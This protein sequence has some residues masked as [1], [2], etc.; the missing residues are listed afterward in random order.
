MK[1]IEV[2]WFNSI[3][4]SLIGL[5]LIDAG[6]EEKAYIGV[7]KGVDERE[8]VENICRFGAKFPVGAARLAMG[9]QTHQK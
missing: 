8:D 3:N 5:V 7:A 1:V 9:L 4:G 6:S 2:T